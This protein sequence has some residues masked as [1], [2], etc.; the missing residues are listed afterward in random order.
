[1]MALAQDYGIVR[2]A[3]SFSTPYRVAVRSRTGLFQP[4]RP[5]KKDWKA[6]IFPS[7]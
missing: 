6:H 7:Y 2:D 3:L 1:M 5:V 4:R